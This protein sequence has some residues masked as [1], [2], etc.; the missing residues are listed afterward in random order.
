MTMTTTPWLDEPTES[1]WVDEATGLPC[2]AR[3]FGNMH[4]WRG[5]VGFVPTTSVEADDDCVH[6]GITWSGTLSVDSLADA[7]LIELAGCDPRHMRWRGFDCYHPG[8]VMPQLNEFSGT[9]RT[10]D[11]VR[12]QCAKLALAIK[13][14]LEKT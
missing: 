9:W 4:P 8:D 1:R 12:G 10:L 11:F 14:A 6:G 7:A 13:D 2:F 3:R 5:Y